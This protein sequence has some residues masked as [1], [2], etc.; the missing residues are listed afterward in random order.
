MRRRISVLTI[1]LLLWVVS[2][3]VMIVFSLYNFADGY[4]KCSSICF[5]IATGLLVFA[6][7]YYHYRSHKYGNHGKHG[8]RK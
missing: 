7:T 6:F 8:T 3:A 1:L 4:V 5:Y 2:A